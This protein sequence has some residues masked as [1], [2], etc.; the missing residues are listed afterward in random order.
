MRIIEAIPR[1][2]R[3]IFL[4]MMGTGCRPS[5]AR[6]LRKKDIQDGKIWFEVA[7]GR[8]EELKSVKQ[9]KIGYFPITAEVQQVLDEA[10]GNLTQW[11]FINPTTGR[12]YSKNINKIW[13]A[14]CDKAG[15]KRINL[16]NAT[17]HSF[18]CQML[19]AGNSKGLVSQLLRHS[20]PRMIERYAEYEEDP[21]RAAVERVRKVDFRKANDNSKT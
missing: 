7:F 18:A 12:P 10:P 21:L 16:Y 3:P 5:E 9:E 17:R 1:K 6:A 20:D 4:F 11:V 8:G 15:V 19:N 13:N 14:A 2:H